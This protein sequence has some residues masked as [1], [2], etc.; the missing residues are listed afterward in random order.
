MPHKRWPRLSTGRVAL[1]VHKSDKHVGAYLGDATSLS[2]L[3]LALERK[4]HGQEVDPSAANT[5][6]CACVCV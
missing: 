2:G 5:S 1:A 4:Q 6:R 3:S